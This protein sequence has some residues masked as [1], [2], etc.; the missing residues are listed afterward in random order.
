M[1]YSVQY[2]NT[3]SPSFRDLNEN[4]QNFINLNSFNFK[5]KLETVFLT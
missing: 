4:M 3:G 2:K 1:Q 5:F